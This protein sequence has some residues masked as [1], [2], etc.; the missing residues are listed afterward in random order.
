MDLL[1]IYVL[2]AIGHVMSMRVINPVR[3]LD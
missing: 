1:D 2:P 3:L